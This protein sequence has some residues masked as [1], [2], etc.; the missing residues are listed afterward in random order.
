MSTLSL[1]LLAHYE[2]L[3]C[4]RNFQVDKRSGG[5]DFATVGHLYRS[6]E[7]G[8][9]HLAEKYGESWLF[10]GPPRAQATEEHFR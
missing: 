9:A 4:L 7:Q 8:V 1:G 6:I 3:R 5:Q 10:V 2:T